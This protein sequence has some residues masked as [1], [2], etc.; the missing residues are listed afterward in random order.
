MHVTWISLGRELILKVAAFSGYV[1]VLT[2]SQPVDCST[3][4]TLPIPI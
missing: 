1:P 3:C 2:I 4:R